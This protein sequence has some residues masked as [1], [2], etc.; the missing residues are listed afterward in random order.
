M[1][2][3]IHALYALGIVV[4]F[5]GWWVA[6]IIERATRKDAEAGEDVLAEIKESL[7]SQTGTAHTRIEWLREQVSDKNER[8]RS[9]VSEQKDIESRAESAEQS[10]RALKGANT[11]YRRRIEALEAEIAE[12]RSEQ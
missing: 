3:W 9:M 5:G 7:E 4:V 6:W 11:R 12:L 2:W 10:R 8:M 1:E